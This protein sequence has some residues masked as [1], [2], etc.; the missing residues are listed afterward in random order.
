[1]LVGTQFDWSDVTWAIAVVS[2][3]STVETSL[4]IACACIPT[5]RP[6]M[7]RVMPAMLGSSSKDASSRQYANRV[8]RVVHDSTTLKTKSNHDNRIYMQKDIHFQSTTELRDMPPKDPYAN[9]HRSS[10]D[11]SLEPA[12]PATSVN[13]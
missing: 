5:L 7:K 4:G 11:I 10:D 6:L 9:S 3:L 13:G 8:D 12:Y 2:Y 1:M